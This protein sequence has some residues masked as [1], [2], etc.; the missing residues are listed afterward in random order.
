MN[1]KL[2]L[3]ASLFAIFIS[4][5]ESAQAFS[6]SEPLPYYGEEFFNELSNGAS[7][8]AL[9]H[10][11]QVVLSSI[12]HPHPGFVAGSFDHIIDSC[13]G[14]GCYQHI[15]L[16]YDAARVFMMGVYYL[17]P[18]G[19]SYAIPDV[20]CNTY[21]RASDFGSN[22]PAPN[23]IPE[24][25]VL[26]TEHTWPQSKFTGR[27]DGRMQKSDLHHLFPTDSEMN[28]NRGN[29]EFG[30]VVQ[31]TKHMKCSASKF[32]NSAKG[33]K[34]VFEPPQNHKG[35]V[36]RALFYFSV[37]YG[38]HIGGE[39]EETLR[40]WH[41]LDPVDEEEARRNEA[42]MKIQGNRNPFIDYPDLVD[43]IRAF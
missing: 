32:G 12:H 9:I 6:L 27:Y 29:H 31:E 25:T 38:M 37:R 18:D 22:P 33:R 8:E 28:S 1:S 20:Y 39:Q 15:S 41:K 4:I 36:A 2:M 35:N 16:G 10:R 3:L 5:N 30:D 23:R 17:T 43:R 21:K 14:T 13:H 11:L 34:D 26:N 40:K 42:I 19:N 24:G 7:D